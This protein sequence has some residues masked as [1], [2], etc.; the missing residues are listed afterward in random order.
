MSMICLFTG[1][2]ASRP[3]KFLGKILQ[4]CTIINEKLW[5]PSCVTLDF[6]WKKTYDSEA[7]NISGHWYWAHISVPI[8]DEHG[9]VEYV[10]ESVR[11]SDDS[12]V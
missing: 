4:E 6:W 3:E 9:E 5:S 1:I 8:M 7:E 10:P 12:F 11:D 2:M